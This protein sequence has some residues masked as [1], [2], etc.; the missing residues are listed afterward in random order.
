MKRIWTS[1]VSLSNKAVV[2]VPVITP[3]FGTLDWLLNEKGNSKTRDP[4]PH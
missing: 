1:D 4:I 2:A 3:A